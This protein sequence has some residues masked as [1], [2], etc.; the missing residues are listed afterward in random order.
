MARRIAIPALLG[1]FLLL[2]SAAEAGGRYER[3]RTLYRIHCAMCLNLWQWA[4]TRLDPEQPPDLQQMAKRWSAGRVCTWM[5]KKT[6]KTQGRGC[7][8]GKVPA[9]DRLDMLY[10]VYRRAQGPIKKPRLRQ[11]RLKLYR[12]PT[13][14]RT[15]E[16][17]RRS[18]RQRYRNR[19][20]LRQMRRRSRGRVERRPGQRVTPRRFTP[21]VPTRRPRGRR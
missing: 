4:P 12:G 6:R 3:G 17:L 15:L 19:M 14:R 18:A 7:Y 8:P 10:Y 1:A 20:L 9:R 11:S 16:A 5:R 2:S 21:R 13:L